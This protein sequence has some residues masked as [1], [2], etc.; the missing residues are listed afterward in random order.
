[1]HPTVL[2]TT[3]FAALLALSA[4]AAANDVLPDEITDGCLK[5]Q[6]DWRVCRGLEGKYIDTTASATA[7]VQ[8]LLAKNGASDTRPASKVFQDNFALYLDN[9]ATVM[10]GPSRNETYTVVFK[11]RYGCPN[12]T[13]YH[14]RYLISMWCMDVVASSSAKCTQNK[15]TLKPLCKST[16][17]KYADSTIESFKNA[18]QCSQPNMNEARDK[19]AAEIRGY[20][21]TAQFSGAAGSC[22]SGD[23][24][25]GNTCGF[26]PLNRVCDPKVCPDAAQ[27]CLA[28]KDALN[29][30]I[31]SGGASGSGASA[32]SPVGGDANASP[33]GAAAADSASGASP[34]PIVPIIL[35]SV[36]GVLFLAIGIFY[37]WRR[38][39]NQRHER[40][41]RNH[42]RDSFEG[43]NGN[44]QSW[45][46][47]P[48][49]PPVP[50]F[51]P[52][53]QQNQQGQQQGGYQY[54]NVAP[55]AAGDFG[56]SPRDANF[57]NNNNNGPMSPTGGY[58]GQQQQYLSHERENLVLP[59]LPGQGAAAGAS[60]AAGA[61]VAG[62]AAYG[63]ASYSS[64]SQQQHGGEVKTSKAN[65]RISSLI[66]DKNVS[67]NEL[68][69]ASLAL[70]D[71]DF[72]DNFAKADANKSL[73]A[74]P[75]LP[76][77]AGAAGAGAAAGGD[78]GVPPPIT[79]YE[80]P[81]Q[82]RVTRTYSPQMDDELDLVEGDVIAVSQVYDD[83]W[84]FGLSLSTG[85]VGVLPM[86]FVE[87]MAAELEIHSIATRTSRFGNPDKLRELREQAAAAA[88]A[89]AANYRT[90][91]SPVR[92]EGSEVGSNVGSRVGANGGKTTTTT[93]TTTT[94]YKSTATPG[95]PSMPYHVDQSRVSVS[96]A[97]MV[98]RDTMFL[99][100]DDDD[101]ASS[102]VPASGVG[103]PAPSAVG[104]NNKA[105]AGA[106]GAAAASGTAES[107]K[108]DIETLMAVLS[109]IAATDRESR[110]LTDLH[111]D[112][113]ALDSD[114]P[115]ARQSI[116]EQIE[117]EKLERQSWAYDDAASEAS[118][119]SKRFSF[120]ALLDVLNDADDDVD[121]DTLANTLLNSYN[122]GS[123]VPNESA[124]ASAVKSGG[125]SYSTSSAAA[126]YSGSAV[127][128][129]TGYASSALSSG[130]SALGGSTTYK[131]TTTTTSSTPVTT[132]TYKTF[133][134][135]AG[136]ASSSSAIGGATTYSTTSTSSPVVT[137]YKTSTPVV[138]YKTTTTP[139]VTTTTYKTS[140]PVTSTFSTSSP[141]ATSYKTTTTTTTS[142]PSY[143]SPLSA[144]TLP[145]L[146][147]GGS[148]GSN[149]TRTYTTTTTTSKPTVVV[150]STSTSAASGAGA[151]GYETRP[152]S[153]LSDLDRLESMLNQEEEM[154]RK[155]RT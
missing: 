85:Q 21:D 113:S 154:L 41:L 109:R 46:P 63:A 18:T 77:A 94:T 129:S 116:L 48:D 20:C 83:G 47:D 14:R 12:Y 93:T 44:K 55:A 146:S 115:K 71:F 72:G 90:P 135:P 107:E 104:T 103:A 82:Y 10:P 42:G 68:L 11:K 122:I 148:S 144:P 66:V 142:S 138:T 5:I 80:R 25:E 86:S 99:G 130:G 87:R 69:R 65:K 81:Q 16:C 73:P 19:G 9:T 58:G 76:T 30:A 151:G 92:E 3:L 137:T 84:G 114:D 95:S 53:Q 96:G 1:M 91:L 127:G 22:I 35:A 139:V 34:A 124:S 125:A 152:V 102:V 140:S 37:F 36:F 32:T 51:V 98:A 119:D 126:G 79:E 60:L 141:V 108:V 89:A 31:P 120:S 149:V 15:A 97:K 78:A 49:M 52:S 38:R 6:K 57:S 147:G 150:S 27:W 117:R 43:G 2:L 111:V 136:G 28:N 88:A 8:L 100:D 61:A 13:H 131:T 143:S 145:P 128:A 70:D 17:E 134:S 62:A 132:T 54:G 153:T 33:T 155:L 133:T 4:P 56:G 101:D 50:D 105:A 75:A 110:I 7:F 59:P 112:F 64:S 29:I 121:P 106:A 24:I 23:E 40:E 45:I 67:L 123:A 26:I 74:V 39:I 118:F